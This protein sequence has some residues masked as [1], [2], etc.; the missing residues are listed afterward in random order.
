VDLFELLFIGAMFLVGIVGNVVQ[1][2]KKKDQPPPPVRRRPRRDPDALARAQGGAVLVPTGPVR[3]LPGR[4]PVEPEPA[5]G[6][7]VAV[8]AGGREEST[9]E[10][11]V[12]DPAGLEVIL[13]FE[14]VTLEPLELAGWDQGAKP[15]PEPVRRTQDATV[16]DWTAEHER[17]HQKYVDV[18]AA[19]PP[20][21]HG[22]LDS[23]RGRKALRQAILTA[24][25]L[26]PPRALRPFDGG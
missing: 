25:V 8:A 5:W 15:R 3:R 18:R 16:V 14:A 4:F 9:S 2:A 23:L 7:P 17:F 13:P 24:E 10:L 22:A 12:A 6:V 20:A 11:P 19:A 26:G 1:S 21:T